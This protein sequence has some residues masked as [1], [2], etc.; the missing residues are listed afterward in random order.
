[1]TQDGVTAELS[2]YLGSFEIKALLKRRDKLVKLINSE[3]KK[4][5]ET[6]ILFNYGD[7]PPGLTI[8]Y[9]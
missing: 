4:Q 2:P 1:L 5:G 7:P 6:E 8:S 9:D 3:I